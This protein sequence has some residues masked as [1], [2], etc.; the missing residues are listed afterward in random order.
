MERKELHKKLYYSALAILVVIFSFLRGEH[1]ALEIIAISFIVLLFISFFVQLFFDVK[2]R[3]RNI[4]VTI[5]FILVITIGTIFFILS[6]EIDPVFT[7]ISNVCFL[8]FI[9]SLYNASLRSFSDP[10]ANIVYTDNLDTPAPEQPSDQP[11][12]TEVKN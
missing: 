6:T 5:Y 11:S 9:I 4:L 3:R 2:H 7:I 12:E 10:D 1:I 8:S